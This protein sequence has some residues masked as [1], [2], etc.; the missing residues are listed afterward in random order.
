LLVQTADPEI[1]D[2]QGL[3]N[4]V[5]FWKGYEGLTTKVPSYMI[6]R[7]RRKMFWDGKDRIYPFKGDRGVR[8]KPDGETSYY[9]PTLSHQAPQSFIPP[10]LKDR[11]EVP[12][13]SP[14]PTQ[15]NARVGKGNNMRRIQV[16]VGD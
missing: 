5:T 2:S 10:R 15:V 3:A 16:P 14:P 12:S 8:V 11:K 6:E 7:A 9:N 4:A 13:D 1:S